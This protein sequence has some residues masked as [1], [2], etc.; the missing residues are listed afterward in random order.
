MAKD[1]LSNPDGQGG[2]PDRVWFQVGQTINIGNYESIRIDVGVAQDV[3]P[4]ESCSSQLA[5]CQ[6]FAIREMK[7]VVEQIGTQGSKETGRRSSGRGR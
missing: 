4:G 1:K 6:S 2:L 5:A 7:K 3:R